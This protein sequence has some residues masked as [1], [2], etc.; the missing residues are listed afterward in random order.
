MFALPLLEKHDL[1][2]CV[3]SGGLSVTKT[4]SLHATSVTCVDSVDNTGCQ[5]L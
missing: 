5:M 2:Y 4:G 3:P 1:V